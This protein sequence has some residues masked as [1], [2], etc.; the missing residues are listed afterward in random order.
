MKRELN[1]L[2]IVLLVIIIAMGLS[3]CSKKADE[4]KT[5]NRIMSS[6]VEN[7]GESTPAPTVDVNASKY[8]ESTVDGVSGDKKNLK[9][10]IESSRSS[11]D[12][13]KYSIDVDSSE[14]LGLLGVDSSYAKKSAISIN[15]SGN[16]LYAI[17]I[18]E[19]DTDKMGDVSDRLL[20]YTINSKV[21]FTGDSSNFE[22]PL[23]S[24]KGNYVVLVMAKDNQTIMNNI[25]SN[26]DTVGKVVASNTISTT[27]P[28]VNKDAAI[29]GVIE[30]TESTPETTVIIENKEVKQSNVDLNDGW[31]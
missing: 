14:K 31:R 7:K 11:E 23:V 28:D 5:S 19:T 26:L 29:S 4:G 25:M 27:A 12:N 20:E 24:G 16:E 17:A 10:V 9:D 15:T 8:I 1:K 18:I 6:D 2:A 30:R 3:G 13:S 22:K 21:R